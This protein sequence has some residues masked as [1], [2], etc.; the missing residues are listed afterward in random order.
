MHCRETI[1]CCRWDKGALPMLVVAVWVW[2]CDGFLQRKDSGRRLTFLRLFFQFVG[3]NPAFALYFS[4][5]WRSW[6]AG[7]TMVFDF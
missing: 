4:D 5:E 1:L 6:T 2:A 7:Q 3:A